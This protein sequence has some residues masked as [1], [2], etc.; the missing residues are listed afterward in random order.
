MLCV[1]FCI[2]ITQYDTI[3]SILFFFYENMSLDSFLEQKVLEFRFSW[4]TQK[5][6]KIFQMIQNLS[7][8]W[9]EIYIQ[10]VFE[11]IFWKEFHHV[12][13]IWSW[14]G[15]LDI[16]WSNIFIQCKKYHRNRKYRD[17]IGVW[18]LRE[19]VWAVSYQIFGKEKIN[20]V[21]LYFVATQDFTSEAKEY[22]QKMKIELYTYE[23]ILS[24]LEDI[25]PLEEFSKDYKDK[26]NIYFYQSSQSSL[27]SSSLLDELQ[28]SE[29]EFYFREVRKIISEKNSRKR[30]YWLIFDNTTLKLFSEKRV[31][32]EQLFHQLKWDL[33][34]SN[35]SDFAKIEKYQDDILR[36]IHILAK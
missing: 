25:Y 23:D 1:L 4:D 20:N 21:S 34:K 8:L 3:I 33:Q 36:A 24:F 17:T 7:P 6:Q 13:K 18:I 19:F 5:S 12:W 2:L 35:S 28:E 11:K 29:Y 30:S 9:F 10:H 27:Y 14:D 26:N 32:N 15:W 31:R 16:M 22:A